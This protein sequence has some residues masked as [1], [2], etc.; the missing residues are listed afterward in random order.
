MD[1]EGGK[2]MGWRTEEKE[3]TEGV[4]IGREYV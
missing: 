4:C 2:I 3:R 1:L